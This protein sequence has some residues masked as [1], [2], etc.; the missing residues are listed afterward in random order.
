MRKGTRLAGR[1]N[2][3]VRRFGAIGHR[4]VLCCALRLSHCRLTNNTAQLVTVGVV[5]LLLCALQL[6]FASSTF[7]PLPDWQSCHHGSVRVACKGHCVQRGTSVGCHG[8][9]VSTIHHVH[10]DLH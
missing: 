5:K 8:K 1:K 10:V 9:D 2:V 4:F 6:P 7:C 3:R